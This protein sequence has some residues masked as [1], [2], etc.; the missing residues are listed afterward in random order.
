MLNCETLIIVKINQSKVPMSNCI[1]LGYRVS[2]P[3]Q[4]AEPSF[5]RCTQTCYVQQKRYRYTIN[6][7]E[8][9]VHTDH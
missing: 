1:T 4:R 8:F 3:E 7:V 9:L 6:E 5:V 2:K